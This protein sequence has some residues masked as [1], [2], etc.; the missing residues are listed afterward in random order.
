MQ[1]RKNGLAQ[2][3]FSFIPNRF[4]IAHTKL[5]ANYGSRTSVSPNSMH[6]KCV[7]MLWCFNRFTLTNRM[8]LTIT[9]AQN[10]CAEMSWGPHVE[11]QK[12]T[13]GLI[14]VCWTRLSQLF[15][16]IGNLHWSHKSFGLVWNYSMIKLWST[17]VWLLNYTGLFERF[18]EIIFKPLSLHLLICTTD[19]LYYRYRKSSI[20]YYKVQKKLF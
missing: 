9:G 6:T 13:S 20:K 16:A 17:R 19:L 1:F 11:V 4:P 12:F 7:R 18:L 14:R 15:F 2:L 10:S 3:A 8:F 5:K